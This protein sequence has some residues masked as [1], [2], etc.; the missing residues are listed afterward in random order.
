M[1]RCVLLAALVV[2]LG[3]GQANP[4]LGGVWLPDRVG[5]A[6]HDLA[7][8]RLPLV[9]VAVEARPKGGRR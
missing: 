5:D 4:D 7:H 6:A 9:L 8:A 2:V 1:K 3:H